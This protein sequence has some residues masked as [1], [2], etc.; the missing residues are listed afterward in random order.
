VLCFKREE[1]ISPGKFMPASSS[2]FLL[3][4]LP[5]RHFKGMIAP[6]SGIKYHTDKEV[7]KYFEVGFRLSFMLQILLIV[8]SF[9]VSWLRIPSELQQ[10]FSALLLRLI[11][12]ISPGTTLCLAFFCNVKAFYSNL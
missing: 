9:E 2:A 6:H 12:S 7:F 4:K 11:S 1:K 10:N 3:S 8:Q 5:L